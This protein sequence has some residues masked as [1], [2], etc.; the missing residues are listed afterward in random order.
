MQTAKIA[1][2]MSVYKNDKP[3][4]LKD[5]VMSILSQS[6]RDYKYFISIDGPI[7]DELRKVLESISDSRIEI[8]ESKDNKGL[9]TIL[10][11]LLD[12]CQKKVMNSSLVWMLMISQ[13][14]TALKNR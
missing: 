12:K 13:F 3:S 6:F 9:A 4:Y 11:G 7:G 10:N 14:L 1:V 2:L 5:A 8:I